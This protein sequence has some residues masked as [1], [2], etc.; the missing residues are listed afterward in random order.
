MKN[1]KYILTVFSFIFLTSCL[2]DDEAVSDDNVGT[3]NFVG[4]GSASLNVSATADGN[5]AYASIPLKV[6]GPTYLN[7]TQD[8]EVNVEIDPS[9]TAVAGTHFELSSTTVTLTP[10][11]NLIGTLPLTIITA[12]ISAPDS[13]TLVLNIT[14]ASGGASEFHGN[15]KQVT[16][17]INY[18]CY[19]DLS[20]TYAMSNSL[21]C[22]TQMV[23][24]IDNGDGTWYLTT[25][26]GG[27][28]QY[29][30]SNS[31]LQNDGSIIVNCGTVLPSNDWGFCD[32]ND[33]GCIT[34]GNWD[35]ATG[36]LTM[37]HT[38][39]FFSWSGG[40]YTSTYVRQ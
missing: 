32:S 20:G 7:I 18:L 2:V 5:E 27:L 38:D 15:K 9:S 23:D 40:S 39:S 21:G 19:V 26:D 4:F 17:N 10:D 13:A 1:F 31:T 28:L 33:I 8:V 30:S 6:E 24:I 29:C 12:G 3:P 36:T 34:G 14:S 11:N 37:T 16:I 25:A 22:G 35:D